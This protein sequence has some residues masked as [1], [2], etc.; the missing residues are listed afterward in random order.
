[1]AAVRSFRGQTEL[2]MVAAVECVV[3]VLQET[4]GAHGQGGHRGEDSLYIRVLILT[5]SY[6]Y[7]SS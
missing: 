7:K 6:Q 5:R 1:M 4:L 3:C 2:I